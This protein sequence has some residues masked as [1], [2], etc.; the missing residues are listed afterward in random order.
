MMMALMLCRYLGDW[1]IQ[2]IPNQSEKFQKQASLAQMQIVSFEYFISHSDPILTNICLLDWKDETILNQ[3]LD[4]NNRWAEL[5]CCTGF[6]KLPYALLYNFQTLFP[7]N[8]AHNLLPIQGRHLL[9]DSFS[10]ISSLLCIRRRRNRETR[11]NHLNKGS[12]S[13][14]V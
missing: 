13:F 11:K 5:Q 8:N 14:S 10:K 3:K 9:T 1:Y 12:A 7:I 2:K 6:L 4:N